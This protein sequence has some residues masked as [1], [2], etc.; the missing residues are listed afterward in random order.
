MQH[1]CKNRHTG[2]KEHICGKLRNWVLLTS[3][4]VNLF[5]FRTLW[6]G[7]QRSS[8]ITEALAG[9]QHI[10][11]SSMR[12]LLHD[13]PSQV[14]AQ[15][16]QQNPP[17]SHWMR[18]LQSKLPLRIV[19][20]EA[21]ANSSQELTVPRRLCHKG[22][23]QERGLQQRDHLREQPKPADDSRRGA[24]SLLFAAN[25]NSNRECRASFPFMRICVNESMNKNYD[26]KVLCVLATT[27]FLFH[28]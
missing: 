9:S 22:R 11:T 8:N 24:V 14:L 2:V 27:N 21:F 1:H 16:P 23:S 6:Q 7:I 13:V 26:E 5:G 25:F 17:Q 12:H 3:L 18:A 28:V 19:P 15:S 20:E 4:N 10:Q